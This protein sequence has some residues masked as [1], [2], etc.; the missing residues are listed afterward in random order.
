MP[1]EQAAPT[2]RRWLGLCLWLAAAAQAAFALALAVLNRL[3]LDRGIAVEVRDDGVGLPLSPR[4]GI[5]LQSMHERA[6]E[7]GGECWV[8]SAPD[9][10]NCGQVRLPLS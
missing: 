7:L 9:G 2:R 4:A 5:G 6:E 8:E 10:G 1:A 3:A